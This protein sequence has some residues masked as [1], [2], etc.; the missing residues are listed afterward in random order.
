M[1]V[2]QA[3][4]LGFVQG[5]TEFLPISSSAH[6][7]LVPWWLHWDSPGLSFDTILHLG[8]ILAV[9]V[10]FRRDLWQII[11]AWTCALLGRQASTPMARLGWW[12]IVGTVP[13]VVLGLALED[14]FQ[15]LFGSP[16]SVGALLLITGAILA[17]SEHFG[18]RLRNLDDLGWL[19]ALVIGLAQACAIAP[20]ISRSG[21]TIGAGLARGLGR[22]DAA[23]FS[24]LLS[25]PIILGAGLQQL[26]HTVTGPILPGQS[27]LLAVGFVMAAISGYL[28]IHFLLQYVQRRKL[29]PFA[30]YCWVVGGLS[31]LAAL[32]GW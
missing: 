29:Y 30:I 23:R 19:D 28:A 6:L 27:L 17:V 7:V 3:F 5:V 26:F 1:D 22:A 15:S 9:V 21:A 2:F 31:L 10:Y 12:L 11:A 18:S 25:V 8:T 20:G 4:I 13:A 16:L 14:F 24:F 32:L